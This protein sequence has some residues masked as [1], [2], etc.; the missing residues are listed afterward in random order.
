MAGDPYKGG[1]FV[2]LNGIAF[3]ADGKCVPQETPYAGSNLF[4]LASGGAI[5]VR[6][7]HQ[8]LVSEQ[9]NGGQF[10]PFG[11]REWDLILPYLQEN[12]R[13]FGISIENDLLTV[14]GVKRKPEEVYR[15]ISA[16][17][18]SVLAAGEG[19]AINE[20]WEED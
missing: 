10:F 16:V 18:L 20:E 2:I 15:T 17:K 4:S 7:P 11:Q 12:E 1:G 19:A 13:L 14:E 6:D 5:F 8:K 3:D 9:L